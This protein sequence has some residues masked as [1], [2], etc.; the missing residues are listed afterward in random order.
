LVELLALQA[1]AHREQG[2]T[3]RALAVLERTLQLAEPEGY[4]RVFVEAG[5]PMARLLYEA[6]SRGLAANYVGRLLAAFPPVPKAPAVDL[7]VAPPYREELVEP[8]SPREL[9]VLGLLAQGL[10][11]RQIAER[12]VISLSTVKGHTSNIYTKL[13][14]GSRTQAVARARALGLLAAG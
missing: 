14:V 13:A 8:L 3:E 5:E 9:E 12:L 4:V 10:S 1:A 11:N 2:D 6:A 7:S